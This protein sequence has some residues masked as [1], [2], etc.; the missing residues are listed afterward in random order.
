MAQRASA[1]D[2]VRVLTIC[3][4]D[5]PPGPL[6]PFAEALHVRW[7]TAVTPATARRT[8]DRIATGRLGALA[9]HFD[10]PDAIYRIAGD[11][12]HLYATE[13]DIF[14]ELH[15]EDLR[16]ADHLTRQ[17]VQA[18]DPNLRILCPLGFGGHADHRLTR[19]AA[20][21]LGVGLWYYYDLPYA[22]R[23]GELPAGM[24]MP[25]GEVTTFPLA[26]EEIEAWASAAAEYRSQVSSFWPDTEH[27]Y[28]ELQAFHD[29]WGGTRLLIAGGPEAESVR[30]APGGF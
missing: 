1:G 4:G 13:A 8:E 7:G 5:P 17:L 15:P 14:G 19:L 2:E 30:R 22:S 20:E 3:A 11:G 16:I 24:G 23:G 9:W 25:D 12:G 18:Q 6:S 10:I 27:L 28:R 21:G 29:A 26:P